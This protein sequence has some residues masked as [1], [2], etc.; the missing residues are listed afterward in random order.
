MMGRSTRRSPSFTQQ[1]HECADSHVIG[2]V[3]E[4]GHDTLKCEA[5][6]HPVGSTLVSG[7]R[8]WITFVK[9]GRGED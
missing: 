3:L 8:T 5:S 4:S 2:P 9:L 6:V 1:S 7:L